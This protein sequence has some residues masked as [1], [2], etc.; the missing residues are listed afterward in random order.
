VR[1]GGAVEVC[2]GV[3]VFISGD[4]LG[5]ALLTGCYL[6]F[7][8][9]ATRLLMHGQ[10]S[11]CGC[12]GSTESPVGVGHLAVDAVAVGFGVAAL[13]RPPERFGGMFSGDVL[14]GLIGVGQS[15]L[16]AYLAFLSITALP[17]LAA[18]RRRL[19]EAVA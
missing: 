8:A 5:A 15:L 12:F 13:I 10:R 17:A 6:V 3:V 7:L 2:V 4:R 19:L 1:S 14:V 9:V 18:A 16:L 11:S